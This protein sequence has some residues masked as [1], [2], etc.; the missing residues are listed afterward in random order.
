MTSQRI[1]WI[2]R[3]TSSDRSCLSFCSSTR[4]KVATRDSSRLAAG[5]IRSSDHA[6]GGLSSNTDTAQPSPLLVGEIVGGPVTE[7]V[8]ERGVRAERCLE[9]CRGAD[10]LQPAVVHERHPVAE[11]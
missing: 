9:F 4:Q 10:R 1:G 2:R 6:P 8:L 3:L 7:D 11:N 5:A